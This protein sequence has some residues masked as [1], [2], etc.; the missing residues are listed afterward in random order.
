MQAL[1]EAVT[2]QKQ[3][4]NLVNEYRCTKYEGSDS[5]DI[6]NRSNRGSWTEF[7]RKMI[8]SL[9]SHILTS[10]GITLWDMVCAEAKQSPSH[11][12]AIKSLP[13]MEPPSDVVMDAIPLDVPGMETA[14]IPLNCK[15]EERSLEPSVF[16]SEER[17]MAR[18]HLTSSNQ[19]L[20][21]RGIL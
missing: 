13:G 5:Q 21:N 8:M 12:S 16:L 17:P 20:A 10:T 15:L 9:E 2:N 14:G 3:R 1:A 18:A 7:R 19:A 11:P 4:K 6:L